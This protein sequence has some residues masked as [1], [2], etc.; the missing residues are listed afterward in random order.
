[1]KLP[2]T[3]FILLAL[4]GLGVSCY[5]LPEWSTQYSTPAVK[6]HFSDVRLG[7]TLD[8]LYELLGKPFY[9]TVIYNG[10]NAPV[11]YDYDVT[12]PHLRT[13]M[14]SGDVTLW[15]QYSRNNGRSGYYKRY[16]IEMRNGLVV[17]VNQDLQD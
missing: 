15:L 6:K 17:R 4:V 2:I 9:A 14:Q 10:T 13:I 8:E 1:M 12:A 16:D 7:T 5:Y 11:D 3:I